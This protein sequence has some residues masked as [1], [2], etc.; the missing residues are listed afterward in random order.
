MLS[1]PLLLE[2]Y[3][4]RAPV[5]RSVRL[6]A[7]VHHHTVKGFPEV[8]A[9]AERLSDALLLRKLS[10]TARFVHQQGDSTF[11]TTLAQRFLDAG[12]DLVTE[13]LTDAQYAALVGNAHVVFDP[14][15][16]RDVQNPY[17]GSAA[18]RRRGRQAGDRS[19]RDLGRGASS[20]GSGSGRRTPTPMSTPSKR[21]FTRWSATSTRSRNGPP[22]NVRGSSPRSDHSNWSGFSNRSPAPPSGAGSRTPRRTPHPR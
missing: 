7:P 18:R 14:A 16:T 21:P 13:N 9:L 4:S 5:G 6:V 22:S 11:H 20:N 1:D 8:V 15:P 19:R 17:I 3:G 2:Q 10:F 12:G